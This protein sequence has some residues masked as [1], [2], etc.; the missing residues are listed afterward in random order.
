LIWRINN[1]PANFTSTCF[2]SDFQS[3]Q[4]DVKLAE[5]MIVKSSLNNPKIRQAYHH[6]CC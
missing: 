3:K 2:Y 6:C 5:K 1:S 4:V